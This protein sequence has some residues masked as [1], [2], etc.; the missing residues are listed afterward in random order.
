MIW[1][2]LELIGLKVFIQYVQSQHFFSPSFIEANKKVFSFPLSG[3]CE[4]LYLCFP[5]ILYIYGVIFL[6][7][8]WIFFSLYP[9]LFRNLNE[10]GRNFLCMGSQF[11]LYLEPLV[12]LSVNNYYYFVK[13]RIS[14]NAFTGRIRDQSNFGWEASEVCK[15]RTDAAIFFVL[16]D[17]QQWWVQCVYCVVF[18]RISCRL[19]TVLKFLATA[20]QANMVLDS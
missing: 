13:L 6:I 4:I 14:F 12:F 19:P 2:N 9:F 5:N 10:F 16:R 8:V 1:N 20:F 15:V 3:M 11:Y 17:Q 18:E 7:L